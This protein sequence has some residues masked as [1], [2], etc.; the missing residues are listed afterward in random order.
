VSL[1]LLVLGAVAFCAAYVCLDLWFE[2]R[3]WLL[4]V[5]AN[6]L[7]LLSG[8]LWTLAVKL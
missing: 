2:H 7:A 8:M 3:R 6:A 4:W 1:A 5:W